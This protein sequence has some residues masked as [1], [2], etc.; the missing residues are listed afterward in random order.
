MLK[1]LC[2]NPVVELKRRKKAESEPQQLRKVVSWTP[3]EVKKCLPQIKGC[4]IMRYQELR[5]WQVYYPGV[6]PASHT[7]TWGAL[8]SE[9][10]AARLCLQWAWKHH[11]ELHG[12]PC[13]WDLQG[14]A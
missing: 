8:L 12:I 2:A 1:K 13:P 10:G 7:K 9:H 4:V 11:E 3:A 14:V 5:K 6:L